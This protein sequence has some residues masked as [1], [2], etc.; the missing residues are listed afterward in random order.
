MLADIIGAQKRLVASFVPLTT[1]FN[2]SNKN[3]TFKL[4]EKRGFY[5]VFSML[6]QSEI[7]MFA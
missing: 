5:M 2:P 7:V 3:A 6:A 1:G 4:A